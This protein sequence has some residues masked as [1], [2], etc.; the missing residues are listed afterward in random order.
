[1][2]TE[3]FKNAMMT[4]KI[5]EQIAA[6][7]DMT[8]KLEVLDSALGSRYDSLAAETIDMKPIE[9]AKVIISRMGSGLNAEMFLNFVTHRQNLIL[10]GMA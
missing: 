6:A 1:M 9:A 3:E 7:G 10:L 4:E 5:S 2:N 8:A